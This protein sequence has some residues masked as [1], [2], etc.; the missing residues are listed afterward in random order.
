MFLLI[1]STKEEVC[2]V[3]QTRYPR[4]LASQHW[5]DSASE[6]ATHKDD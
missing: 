4:D 5:I 3:Q 2:P 1:E 6:D